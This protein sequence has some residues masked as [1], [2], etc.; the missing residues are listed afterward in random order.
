MKTFYLE[1]YG[2]QMNRADSNT[3]S[4][5][6]KEAGFSEVS[7]Y[8]SANNIIINTCSVRKHA[9][10]RVFARVKLFGSYKRTKNKNAKIIVMGCMAKNNKDELYNLKVDRVFDVYNEE[11]IIDFLLGLDFIEKD[12]DSEYNFKKSYI[13]SEYKH[14]AYLPI[15]HG[16][17]NWCTYCIVPH[18]RGSMV[19]RPLNDVLDNLKYLIDSGAKEITLLGQ[20]V[21]SY[22]LDNK[23]SNFVELLKKCD[24]IIGRDK[25]IWL[26]FMTSHPKDFTKEL[27]YAIFD[28]NSVCNSL[29]LPFQ[30]G[31]DRILKLMNR[32]YSLKDYLE[33]VS[34][35]RERDNLFSISTDV[36]V[37]FGDETESE[38]EETL[39]L[40]S[41]VVFE[42][43]FLYKYSERVGSVAEKQKIKYSEE[44]GSIRLNKL[45]DF[46]RNISY[47]QL[48][49]Q[50]G[51]TLKVMIEG[52]AKDK[53]N[54]LGRSYE[55]R[56]V[57]V[58]NDNGKDYK[59]GSILDVHI[60]YTKAQMLIGAIINQ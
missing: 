36:L 29:H 25:S 8:E 53:K 33:K 39:N 54:Y 2:C 3:L 55:N 11:Q 42:E 27:A 13:D 34:Y 48:K 12:F 22:G 28:L 20:N 10:D 32:K 56:T 6:L 51:K 15:S 4:N 18:T 35:L 47:K 31:S 14:K 59:S 5:K 37:G 7:D 24:D 49:K 1:N 52:I 38:F 16:C 46:Q 9:E 43:A 60:L 50:I 21:N 30:S 17:D 23:E 44:V 40:L 26:R 45:I 41:T 57:I 58:N 19:S